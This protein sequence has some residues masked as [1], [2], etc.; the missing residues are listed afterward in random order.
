VAAHGAA[1][2]YEYQAIEFTRTADELERLRA[3]YK[4]DHSAKIV[5]ESEHVISIQN[6]GWMSKLSSPEP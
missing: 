6:E 5:S 2:R 4:V 3:R 1:S